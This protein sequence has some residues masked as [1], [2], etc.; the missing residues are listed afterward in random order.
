[1]HLSPGHGEGRAPQSDDESSASSD[2][3]DMGG[4]VYALAD[5]DLEPDVEALPLRE[6]EHSNRDRQAHLDRFDELLSRGL[7]RSSDTAASSVS[8]RTLK[9]SASMPNMWVVQFTLGSDSEEDELTVQGAREHGGGGGGGGGHFLDTSATQHARVTRKGTAPPTLTLKLHRGAAAASPAAAAPAAATPTTAPPPATAATVAAVAA[10]P[11][12]EL[13]RTQA[14]ALPN[15]PPSSSR[16]SLWLASSSLEG[17][18]ALASASTSAANK[19]LSTASS[20][21]SASAS[22]GAS[23]STSS[24]TSSRTMQQQLAALPVTLSQTLQSAALARAFL[25]FSERQFCAENILFWE[26]S[27][28]TA[29]LSALAPPPAARAPAGSARALP[30]R[31]GHAAGARRRPLARDRCNCHSCTRFQTPRLLV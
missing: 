7:R 20:G 26:E 9:R 14:F 1:M 10:P 5:S 15:S 23:S 8:S 31:G 4:D 11:L 3:D 29:A 24:S 21:A 22:A 6:R 12:R 25:A 27:K 28:P 19:H 16:S 13:P 17:L 18:S 2:S 30:V